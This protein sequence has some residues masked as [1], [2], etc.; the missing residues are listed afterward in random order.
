ML[1]LTSSRRRDEMPLYEYICD[2]CQLHKEMILPLS[3]CDEKTIC[4]VCER[5]MRKIIFPVVTALPHDKRKWG[6]S[7]YRK[8][9]RGEKLSKSKHPKFTP[10]IKREDRKDD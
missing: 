9:D 1:S 7:L 8:H 3:R 2:G 5:K 10:L 6:T 4:P